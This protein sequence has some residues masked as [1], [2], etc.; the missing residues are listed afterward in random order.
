M[1]PKA[2]HRILSLASS[3]LL[4]A[5]ASAAGQV[6]GGPVTKATK[7]LGLAN[8]IWITPSLDLDGSVRGVLRTEAGE[9]LYL[10]DG[11]LVYEDRN[12]DGLRRGTLSG[13]LMPMAESAESF[14]PHK[15]AVEILVTGRWTEDELGRGAFEAQAMAVVGGPQMTRVAVADLHGKFAAIEHESLGQ[16][17]A[18]V[19]HLRHPR[20]GEYEPRTVLGLSSKSADGRTLA[21]FGERDLGG[22]IVC[23][24]GDPSIDGSEIGNRTLA[25][26][27]LRDVGGVIVC[28]KGGYTVDGKQIENRSLRDLAPREDQST[29]CMFLARWSAQR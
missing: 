13:H 16:A 15:K 18:A 8:G 7:D 19:R 21:T 10:L 14:V 1:I 26:P 6:P 5:A 23:P 27:G 24:K 3:L 25:Q 28:P 4:V 29:A 12:A 17:G 9:A 11:R 2:Q 22:V 20:L